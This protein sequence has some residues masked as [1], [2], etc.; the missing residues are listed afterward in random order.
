MA[1]PEHIFSNR[2]FKSPTLYTGALSWCFTTPTNAEQAK[3]EPISS[4]RFQDGDLHPSPPQ[5]IHHSG[6][7][8]AMA[9]LAS[10][11]QG[12]GSDLEYM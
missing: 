6:P 4:T 7:S 3:S 9:S 5:R 12:A 2:N 10:A 11:S 8:G 1:L